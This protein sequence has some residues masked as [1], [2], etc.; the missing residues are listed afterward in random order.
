MTATEA[1][2]LP[3]YCNNAIDMKEAYLIV[4]AVKVY[5]LNNTLAVYGDIYII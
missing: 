2:R 1:N 5:R 4:F 3:Y